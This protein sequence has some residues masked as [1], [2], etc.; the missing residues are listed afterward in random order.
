LGR[1]IVVMRKL[2]LWIGLFVVLGWVSGASAAPIQWTV[3]SGGNDHYYEFVDNGL[4]ITW[5]DARDAAEQSGGYLAVITSGAEISWVKTNVIAPEDPG[6]PV[7]GPWLGGYQDTGSPAYSEPA[8]GWTWVTGEVWSY[9]GW[10]GTSPTNGGPG[11]ENYLHYWT[12]ENLWW[13]DTIHN[14][15]DMF[16]YVAEYETN[17]IPEPSTAL[18]LGIGLS[19]LAATSGRRPSS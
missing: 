6:F 7:T 19:A 13:N 18:L 14:P 12:W 4:A 1:E 17:P 10:G 15:G 16:S 2:G 8:G 11:G 9:T 3:A 5:T